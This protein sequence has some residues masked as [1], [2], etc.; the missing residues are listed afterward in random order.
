[1]RVT[2]LAC[3]VLLCAGS[4]SDTQENGVIAYRYQGPVTPYSLW[5]VLPDGSGARQKLRLGQ[6]S[7]F[8]PHW[9]SDGRRL[10][11]SRA[12]GIYIAETTGDTGIVPSF[13]PPRRIASFSW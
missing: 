6:D 5:V 1:M 2:A 4:S 13:S 7:S 3:V 9:S 10:V 12:S 8:D 11:F